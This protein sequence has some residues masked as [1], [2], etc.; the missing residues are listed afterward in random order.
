MHNS[1][2][3]QLNIL[4]LPDEILLVILKKLNMIDVLS[5][6]NAVNRR[7]DRLT[8]DYSYIRDLDVTDIVSISSLCNQP[9]SVN[10]QILCKICQKI[11]P[12]IHH[13][14]HQLTVEE[15]S[16]KQL[17]FATNYPQLFSLSLVDF[18]EETLLKSLT[19]MIFNFARRTS[20]QMIEYE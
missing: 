12:R 19:G 15:H 6:L 17:L 9:S 10:P 8:V 18:H 14:V 3:D 2:K 5:S 20:N 7:F 11:L 4:D 16:M 13:L 1:P